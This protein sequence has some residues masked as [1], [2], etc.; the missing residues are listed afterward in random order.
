MLISTSPTEITAGNHDAP[1]ESLQQE[2]PS[3]DP[4]VAMQEIVDQLRMSARR[5]MAGMRGLTIQPTDLVGMA[6]L[7]LCDRDID[8]VSDNVGLYV[9]AMSQILLD[10]LRKRRTLRRGGDQ[11]RIPLDQ[12]TQPLAKEG[13]DEIEFLEVIEELQ[14]LGHNRQY[15]VA[16]QKIV[17]GLSAPERGALLGVSD[18][19]IESDLRAIRLHLKRRLTERGRTNHSESSLET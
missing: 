14:T 5:M 6:F 4:Q 9:K 8:A 2:S 17:A 16:Y 11:S 7:K 1:Q 3:C 15:Q 19:T 10:H 18:S 13:I 12:W